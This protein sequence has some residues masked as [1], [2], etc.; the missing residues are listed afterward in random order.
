[1]MGI[2]QVSRD[3]PPPANITLIKPLTCV[4][5]FMDDKCGVLSER[6]STYVIGVGFLACM[7]ALMDTQITALAESFSTD[8]TGHGFLS[9]VDQ[10]V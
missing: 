6:L 1:M 5:T 4:V 3:K 7:C 2:K 8:H 10:S 9:C